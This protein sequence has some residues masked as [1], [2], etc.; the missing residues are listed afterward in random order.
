MSPATQAWPEVC[1]QDHHGVPTL[2]RSGKPWFGLGAERPFIGDNV[3][4]FRTLSSAGAQFLQCDATCSEDIYHPE[5]RF[6]HGPD[7]FDGSAQDQYFQKVLGDKPEALLLLRVYAGAPDWWLDAHPDHLQVYADG[8]TERE[9]QRA[10]MKRLPSLASPLWREECAQAMRE[11][12]R[13]LIRSGWSR[14]VGAFLVS[15]GITWE[16]AIPGTDGLPDYS[17]QAVRYFR[18]FLRKK[19]GNAA[20]LS[21]A[22]GRPSRIDA[23]EIPGRERR[24]RAGGEVGLRA[25]P[26]EQ[27]VIDH[28]QTLSEMTADILLA[29]C[30]AAKEESQGALT[31]GAFYGYTLTAREQTPFTGLYGAGGFLGGHHALGRV[32][33]SPHLDFLASPYAY[34]NRR[35]S[36]GMLFEHGPLGT[37]HRHG[38]AWFD[39]NDNYTFINPTNGD[40]RLISLDVGAAETFEETVVML[41]WAFGLALA[42]GKHLW[43][44]ELTGWLNDYRPNFDHPAVLEEI[45][46]LQ[47]LGERL[48]TR[49]RSNRSQIAIVLDEFSIAHQTLDHRAFEQKVYRAMAPLMRMGCAVEVLLLEDLLEESHP[50]WKIVAPFGIHDSAAIR[51]LAAYRDRQPQIKFCWNEEAGFYPE[52][53]EVRKFAVD[54]G[55]HFFAPDGVCAW[56]NASML[57]VQGDMQEV[58]FDRPRSGVEMFSGRPFSTDASKIISPCRNPSRPPCLSGNPTNLIHEHHHHEPLQSAFYGLVPAVCPPP[59]CRG[60]TRSAAGTRGGRRFLAIPIHG[61]FVGGGG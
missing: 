47:Q 10:G 11:F 23:A 51:R 52:P 17:P 36:N 20:A 25:T 48:V 9:L 50:A 4:L 60:R 39:E 33:R 2:H 12:V 6:W 28:Q 26:G 40:P 18:D 61:R 15:S 13:W 1:I 35:P 38:K 3:A 57:L 14:H 44:T 49:D 41:R 56:E 19:Y 45:D 31:L 27:D 42:R 5:L 21:E 32:V 54:A 37:C 29:L 59:A 16:W 22:W 30:E 7:E 55:V 53:C 34:S 8:T 58:A 46:R 24:E 43:L